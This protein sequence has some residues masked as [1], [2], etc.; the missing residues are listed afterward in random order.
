MPEPSAL[1]GLQFPSSPYLPFIYSITIF[2]TPM[3]SLF[4]RMQSRFYASSPRFEAL[5]AALEAL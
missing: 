5:W 4:P 2:Y 1:T 3:L